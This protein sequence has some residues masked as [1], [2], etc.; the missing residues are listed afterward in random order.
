MFSKIYAWLVLFIAV[1][2]EGDFYEISKGIYL[3]CSSKEVIFGNHVI[4]MYMWKL[5]DILWGIDI[6]QKN[7]VVCQSKNNKNWASA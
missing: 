5:K 2:F 3:F 7:I 6:I 4:C 1:E